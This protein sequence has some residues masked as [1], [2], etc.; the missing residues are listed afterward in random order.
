MRPSDHYNSEAIEWSAQR[1]GQDW[2]DENCLAAV[3]WLTSLLPQEEWEPRAAAV[4]ARF[5]AA[6]REWAEGHRTP[7]YDSSD[8]I[9]W[10]IHLARHYADPSLRPDF[11]EPDGY[12]IAVV[13]KRLGEIVS[14]L[15]R[16]DGA[17]HRASA[18]MRRASQPDDAI[19]ELL[20]AGS[21]ARRGWTGVEFVPEAPPAKRHDL[22]VSRGSSNWAVECKRAGRSE[23]AKNERA[24]AERIAQEVH[25]LS[26]R[27]GRSIVAVVRFKA[28]IADLQ[29]DYLAVK[30]KGSLSSILPREWDDSG[31]SGVVGSADMQRL[32]RA[33]R[34][35]DIYFGSSR[36]VELILGGYDP[37]VD[38][39]VGGDWKSSA[40]RPFHAHSVGRV[41]LV[42][43]KIDSEESARRKASHF[44]GIV[45]RAAAQLPGDR[46]GAIH[47]GYE[48]VGG[49]SVDGHRHLLNQEQMQDFEVGES[50]LRFVYGNY[51]MPEHVTAR[52]ESAAVSETT[53]WYPVGSIKTEQPL[54]GHLLFSDQAG[55]PG[56]HF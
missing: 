39:S 13:F 45:G 8:L 2:R 35:D 29:E 25:E 56:A 21:Y 49:N 7:L 11:Y 18:M 48:A 12:R 53:A 40:G 50:N 17:E 20:V 41:S 16:I 6:K 19:Y 37:S 43:W 38:F 54:P 27:T 51:F 36:M 46:P 1:H 23:Y 9:G 34:R 26:A 22:N 14:D 28:E 15:R 55:T 3:E 44:R 31:G 5:Q 52:M 10:Y 33:L 47:V 24:A 4:E 32:I 30:A 42:A